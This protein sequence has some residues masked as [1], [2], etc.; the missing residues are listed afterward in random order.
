MMNDT[1]RE[2]VIVLER[3]R[4]TL[5]Q[6]VQILGISNL[7]VHQ[8]YTQKELSPASRNTVERILFY[9]KRQATF[10][11]FHQ[12]NTT[13]SP[14]SKLTAKRLSLEHHHHIIYLPSPPGWES[15]RVCPLV[16]YYLHEV[17]QDG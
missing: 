1:P 17:L 14:K 7:K 16:S 8:R 5:Q 10:Y 4:V 6:S 12:L 9:T 15:S 11:P 2:R 13:T 3:A